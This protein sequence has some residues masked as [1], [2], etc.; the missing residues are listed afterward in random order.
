GGARAVAP[1]GPLRRASRRRAR[2]AR[3]RRRDLRARAAGARGLPDR[4]GV[5]AVREA[6]GMSH[7]ARLTDRAERVAAPLSALFELTGRCNL[8]CGHCYL[9]IAHP[10]EELTTAEACAVVDQL[11]DAGTLFLTL[12]GGE[13]FLRPDA[14]AIARHARARGL[15]LRLFTNA[16]RID[17]R[18]ARE[19]AAVR[20]LG[21]E[22][23][24]YGTHADVHD[25]VTKRRRTLRRTLRGLL[26]LRRAGV[27]VALKAPLL[28]PVAGEI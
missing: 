12:T 27:S 26:H 8:D 15:A 7:L 18:L 16:T 10:P 13:L 21:V 14:L 1:R 23:S 3:P 9:D 19:I 6:G 17:A 20:P 4:R 2:A 22:V 11:A 24:I 25:G 5:P 28:H